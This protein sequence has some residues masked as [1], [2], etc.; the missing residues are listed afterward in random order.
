VTHD[1]DLAGELAA[2]ASALAEARPEGD[3][4]ARSLRGLHRRLERIVELLIGR[5]V[6]SGRDAALLERYVAAAR[7]RV[8]LRVI[9]DRREVASTEIDCGALLPLCKARCC[10]FRVALSAEEVRERRLGW[11]LEEPYVLERGDHG[12][13]VHLADEATGGGCTCYDVRPATCR[14]YDC[15]NDRRVWLDFERRI[16][17]PMPDH[18]KRPR[19]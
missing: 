15:R 2:I 13:C 12:Y 4:E 5:G 9:D 7:P 3:Q 17:A 1:P 16:P 8:E 19:F 14:A 18:V 11:A 6:L 10:S